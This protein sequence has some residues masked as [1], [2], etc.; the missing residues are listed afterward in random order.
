MVHPDSYPPKPNLKKEEVRGNWGLTLVSLVLFVVI[1]MFFYQEQ[2]SFVVFLVSVLFIHEGGHFVAMKVFKYENVR[3]LFIP[4]M[5][6]FV[7]GSK[8]I[9]S[10]R[11]SFIVVLLGPLPGVFIGSLGLYL[12][13]LFQMDWILTLSFIFIFLNVMNLLPLDPLDGGQLFKLFVYEGRD[14]FLMI[15]A[16]FSSLFVIFIGIIIEDWV[17][18]VFGFLM[19]IR[20]RAMQ[21]NY[22]FRRDFSKLDVNYFTTYEDLSNRDYY[23]IKSEILE[24][25]P[26]LKSMHED[27]LDGDENGTMIA[28]EVNAL[29]IPP[30]VKDASR[31][32]KFIVIFLWL[33]GLFVPI[34]LFYVLDFDWY[35]AKR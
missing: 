20:V 31:L 29:L 9:Y 14:L 1:F 7:Q 12:S 33:L 28:E 5:G 15:F 4:L 8:P 19:G 30:V 11:D 24:K 35:F 2:L 18:A 22:V 17:V 27:D 25:N 13:A 32:F 26:T 21:K 16:L 23:L 34:F 6:A 3:M 10:Q